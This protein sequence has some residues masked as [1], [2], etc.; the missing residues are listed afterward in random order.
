M[1][2]DATIWAVEKA[3]E[4]RDERSESAQ[5]VVNDKVFILLGFGRGRGWA[6]LP[7]PQECS[8]LILCVTNLYY[9]TDDPT[10][11]LFMVV[12][13]EGRAAVWGLSDREG[14]SSPQKKKS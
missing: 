14:V 10:G 11:Q 5:A 12:E 2:E 8:E 3:V 9:S 6:G 4:N 7:G 1:S 13:I